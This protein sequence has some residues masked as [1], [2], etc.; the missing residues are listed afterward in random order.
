MT[1]FAAMLAYTPFVHPLPG[2]WN[3]WPILLLPLCVAVAIVYKSIKCATMDRVPREAA[4]AF[5]WI[6]V[7]MTAAGA[8]LMGIMELLERT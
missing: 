8:V 5:L 4:M 2:S 1:L 7:G 6:L 3:V